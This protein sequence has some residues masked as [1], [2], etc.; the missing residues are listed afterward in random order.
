MNDTD[1]R[2]A[3]QN[4]RQTLVHEHA[5]LDAEQRYDKALMAADALEVAGIISSREWREL[6]KEANAFIFH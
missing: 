6:V 4:W 3:L 5:S 1:K 2:Q